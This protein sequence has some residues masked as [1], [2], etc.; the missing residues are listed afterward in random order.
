M[1]LADGRIAVADGGSLQLRMFSRQGRFLSASAG[2][3]TGTGQI[4]NMRWVRRLRGDTIAIGAGL[5]MVSF[6]SQEG[7]FL[8][9]AELPPRADGRAPSPF[10]LFALLH[11]GLGVAAPL[12]NPAPHPIGARWIDTLALALVTDTSRNPRAFGTFPY[13]VLEQVEN[14]PTPVW[15]S[16]TAVVAAD[17]DHFYVGFGDNYAIRV[18][19]ASGTLQSIIGRSW[20]PVPVTDD[21][22]EHWVIEWSKLWVTTTGTERDRDVQKVRESPWAEKLPAFTQFIVDRGGRLW[23]RGAHWQ[24]AIGAGSLSD[25]PAVPSTW[26]VF[27]VRGRWLGDVTMPADF[28]PFEI[29]ADYVAGVMRSGGVNQVAIYDLS[30]RK[31]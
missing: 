26:S 24:D 1:L 15:L 2:R 25:S 20:T 21:D 27:D 9:A 16:A 13:I 4:L 30:A 11:G 8:R 14:R 3:G 29:G 28:Q 12:P 19:S 31:Q 22:W 7:R 18:Y 5:S 17:D 23:V 10:L 6:Y